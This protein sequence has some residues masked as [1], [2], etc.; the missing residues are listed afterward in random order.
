[1]PLTHKSSSTAF[2]YALKV[3]R[4]LKK[5]SLKV[6]DIVYTEEVVAFIKSYFRLNYEDIVRISYEYQ[7]GERKKEHLLVIERINTK[8]T[9]L[10]SYED[11]T[12]FAIA[13]LEK[14]N[15]DWEP[16]TSLKFSVDL[17][18]VPVFDIGVFPYVKSEKG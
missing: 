18:S 3:V 8:K 13:L 6:A 1:M 7:A 5:S 2:Y 16:V 12:E 9:L 14:Y 15:I 17:D 4:P 10:L 11:S